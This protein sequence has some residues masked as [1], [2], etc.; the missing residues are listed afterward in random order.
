MLI[1][2]FPFIDRLL[3]VDKTGT[4][5]ADVP[6]IVEIHGQNFAFRDWYKGISQKWEP[7]ISE[8]YQRQ[9]PPIVNVIAISIPIK[10]STALQ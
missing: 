6:E 4:L 10:S 7:S 2:D 5:M 3:L 1:Q 8:I 9:A